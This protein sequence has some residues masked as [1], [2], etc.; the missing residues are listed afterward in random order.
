MTTG[1]RRVVTLGGVEFCS[2]QKGFGMHSG[3]LATATQ[4]TTA[5]LGAA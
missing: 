2:H 1:R 4:E 3:N 5:L